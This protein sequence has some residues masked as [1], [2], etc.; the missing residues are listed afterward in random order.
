MHAELTQAKRSDIA[1]K[2]NDPES[3][4]QV[5]ILLADVPIVAPNLHRACSIVFL[6]SILSNMTPEVQ[7]WGQVIKVICKIPLADLPALTS[8]QVDSTEDVNIYRKH[9]PNSHDNLLATRQKDKVGV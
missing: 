5:S 7:L 4:S 9:T 1:A 6:T 2:F 8:S 3:L